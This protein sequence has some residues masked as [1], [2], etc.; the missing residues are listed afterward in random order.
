MHLLRRTGTTIAIALTAAFAL[1]SCA[2]DD[3][4][5]TQ[6]TGDAAL[7]PAA[8]GTTSYPLTLTTPYGETVLAERPERIAV[9]GGL[10]DEDAVLALGVAPVVGIEG[11]AWSWLEGTRIDEVQSTVDPW[12]DAVQI[13]TIAAAEPDL[14]VASTFAGVGDAFDR[15]AAVAPVLVVEPVADFEWDWRELTRAVGEALDLSAKAEEI[16]TAAD[17]HVVDAVA[18]HPEYAG[19][20]I[21]ILI[22]RGP[23]TGLEFVNVQG[24]IAE[25]LLSGLGFAPHP[26]AAALAAGEFGEVPLENLA[27]VDADAIVVAEHGGEGTPEEAKQWLESSPL[28]QSLGAVQRGAVGFVQANP[29]SGSLDLA[30]ALSYPSAL[31]VVWTVDE[32]NTAFDGL[33]DA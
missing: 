31:S 24:S 14:I 23:A 12:A 27:L 15:L 19:R 1:T 18:A 11:S 5:G 32:L 22:N 33:F 4:T 3:A 13:E 16:V 21:A 17:G 2:T 9:I 28:Y 6:P 26:N 25:E 10:G 8:E 20:T 30:W 7:L 29:E